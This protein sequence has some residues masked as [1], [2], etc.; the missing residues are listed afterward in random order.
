MTGPTR[1]RKLTYMRNI[2]VPNK[3][4]KPVIVSAVQFS[5]WPFTV[6]YVRLQG[7]IS[8]IDKCGKHM[9]N[10]GYYLYREGD[11]IVATLSDGRQC[12]TS[13]EGMKAYS[14]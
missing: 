12:V 6:D 1:K 7:G 13:E 11:N 14:A 2:E 3:G 5:P 10:G 8:F 4:V 9:N